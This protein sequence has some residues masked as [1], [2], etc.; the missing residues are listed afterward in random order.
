MSILVWVGLF[1]LTS[2]GWAWVLFLG[3]A[4]KLEGTL[5]SGFLIDAFAPR[6]S[7]AGIKLFAALTWAAAG[8]WFLVGLFVPEVR[9]AW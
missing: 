8:V 3:G 5:A 7:A 1:G 9:F 4:E 6:W 2:L